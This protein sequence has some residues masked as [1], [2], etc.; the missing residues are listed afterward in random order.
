MGETVAVSVTLVPVVTLLEESASVVVVEVVEEPDDEFP[1]EPHP[2]KTQSMTK[3]MLQERTLLS[4][5][6]FM[7]HFLSKKAGGESSTQTHGK[8]NR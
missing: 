3:A 5:L 7:P 2:D 6:S 8:G 1:E 4:V